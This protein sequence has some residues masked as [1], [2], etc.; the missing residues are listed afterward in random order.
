M[1]DA[2]AERYFKINC[3][4]FTPNN[5]RMKDIVQM[6]KDLHADGIVDVALQFC[7]L[8]E[9]ESFAVEKA[10]RRPAFRLCTSRPTTPARMQANC[11]PGLRLSWKPFRA[12]RSSG[13]PQAPRSLPSKPSLAYQSTRQLLFH[14]NLGHLGK[15]FPWLVKRFVKELYVGKY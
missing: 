15:P 4:V 8:Y 10:A 7:T 3:A 1:L 12:I 6:A 9:M 13:L 11:K 14:G 5:Q 2:I